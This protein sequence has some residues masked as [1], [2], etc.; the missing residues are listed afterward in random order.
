VIHKPATLTALSHALLHGV[1]LAPKA[2]TTDDDFTTVLPWEPEDFQPVLHQ[3]AGKIAAA[4]SCSIDSALALIR[5]HAFAEAR[6][7]TDV[8]HDVLHNHLT[9]P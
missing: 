8:A 6:S 9:L 2:I 5:A 4:T 3:A 7:V 1:L